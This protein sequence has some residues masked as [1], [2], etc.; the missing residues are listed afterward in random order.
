MMKIK[1][2]IT[3]LIMCFGVM[4]VAATPTISNVTA[5]QHSPWN[6]KVDISYTIN[7][8]ISGYCREYGLI[9]SLK[10]TAVDR[11]KDITYTATTLSGEASLA[12]GTHKVE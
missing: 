2:L 11:T 8:D 10:V 6:G 9:P 3:T 12:M 5:Q 4:T 7:G 1:M